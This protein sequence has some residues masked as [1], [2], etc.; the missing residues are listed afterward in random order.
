MHGWMGYYSIFY[1]H[2]H[3]FKSFIYFFFKKGRNGK[4][5]A[6][7][8]GLSCA[9]NKN[10]KKKERE[11]PWQVVKCES[12]RP[13]F[14][15]SRFFVFLWARRSHVGACASD[16]IESSNMWSS[17]WRCGWSWRQNNIRLLEDATGGWP[18]LRN[19]RARWCLFGPMTSLF[20]FSF[21]C[22]THR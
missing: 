11:S 9:Q 18:V 7:P 16:L 21:V 8:G 3:E 4:C 6:V 12:T 13:M 19:R 10:K 1:F 2:P 22:N 15:S 14:K 20:I 5:C 17:R